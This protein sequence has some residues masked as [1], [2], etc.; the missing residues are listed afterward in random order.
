MGHGAEGMKYR[1][2]W[3]FPV[4]FSPHHPNRLYAASNHLHMSTDQG[5]SWTIVSPD[6]TRNDSSKL[7]ASGGPITKDNTG[8]EYYCT[9]FAAC[10][11]PLEE[12]LIWT[13]SDDGL[14]HVSTDDGASWTNV[15]PSDLPEWTMINSVEPDPFNK[16]GLYI[17]G[18]RYKLGDYKPYLYHTTDYGQTWNKITNGI[19]NDH[20]TRV[21]RADPNAEGVLYAGTETA[22]YVSFDNGQN[23]QSLQLNLPIVPITD[24]AV[25]NDNLVAATQGR[26]FWIID[27]LTV[28]H[29]AA[30]ADPDLGENYLFKPQ[31]SY[32]MSG[33]SGG[34]SLTR[35]T[36]HPGGVM[37][38][39]YLQEE[40]NDSTEVVVAFY[41]ADGDS[42]C[43]FST[44]AEEEAYQIKDLK[45]G[46]N[47]LRWNMRYPDAK[48]FE[49]RIFWWG[50]LNGPLAVPGP[51]K[52]KL[53]VGN[54]EYAKDFRILKDPRSE[55][56]PEDFDAQFAFIEG[57]N[58]KVSEAH[59]TIEE[60]RDVRGQLD[61]LRERIGD[62]EEHEQIRT[63]IALIDSVMTDVEQNLYQTQNQSAQDPLNFPIRLT[64]KL[65]HLNSLNGNGNYPPTEQSVE[66]KEELSRQIDVQLDRYEQIRTHEIP[67]LNT[68]I[69]DAQIEA[70]VLKNRKSI[71]N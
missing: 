51:Y 58:E 69:R 64:N 40:W 38:H 60:I 10:E 31:D 29:Q 1:F 34:P 25:K 41:E 21:L 68:L 27:D 14:I 19:A 48:D 52:V 62:N 7:V 67:V 36:N 53:F 32:R 43:S 28:L 16:G 5:R 23:W 49:G 30:K 35:G 39:Y 46:G 11:S 56:T 55:S 61:G 12:G 17:A 33:G 3:N 4:F 59:E 42:I 37:V 70:I 8:V 50:S 65:A 26:S 2:Q 57:I 71:M 47:T 13:G 6:L 45:S 24:L 18:T 63:Q 54:E 22:M 15:T 66:V 44:A 20:F 9:I